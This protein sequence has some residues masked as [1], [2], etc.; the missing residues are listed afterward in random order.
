MV[1]VIVLIGVLALT[2]A[3]KFMNS[4]ADARIAV[5]K[6]FEAAF[7]AANEIVMAKAEVAGILDGTGKE[8]NIPG[9]D[10]YVRD[11]YISV[12]PTHLHSAMSIDGLTV[13][14]YDDWTFIYFGEER[15]GERF[16]ADQCYIQLMQ[17]QDSETETDG[18][19]IFRKFGG[20]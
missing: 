19:K 12:K 9:T 5:L 6:G 18:L 14:E 10:L 16:K 3:P 15:D 20:C 13:S 1:V 8:K 7:Y 17:Y 11:N 4:Q 2:A